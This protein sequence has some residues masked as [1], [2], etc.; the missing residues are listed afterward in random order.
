MP[1][2]LLTFPRLAPRLQATGNCTSPSRR[3]SVANLTNIT[4]R[5]NPV[6]TARIS[7]MCGRYRLSRP[8]RVAEDF[9]AGPWEKAEP[10]GNVEPRGIA[11]PDPLKPRYNI[12]PTQPVITVRQEGLGRVLAVARWGLMPSWAKDLSMGASLINGRSET[13][14]EKP[15]FRESFRQRRCLIPADGFYE[16]E[17]DGK[18]KRPF[19]F[20]MK[21]GSLFGFAGIWDRWRAPDGEWVE[22]CC[23]LTTA[24]NEL[25]KDVHDRMP[26]ILPR[27]QYEVWLKTPAD[28]AER[29]VDLLV[30]LDAGV[31]RGYAV[32]SLVNRPQNDSPE[33]AQE[34]V[35]ERSGNLELFG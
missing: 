33:C 10:W 9:D 25:L 11:G 27:A 17:K 2:K 19:H 22:S 28:E 3:H 7:G 20:A 16:W 1:P 15:A 24:A 29:L 5:G 8:E 26:A 18:A 35:S 14:L 23:I 30:P 13:V 12:A 31:M 6:P 21:D 34:A 32:S 4:Q